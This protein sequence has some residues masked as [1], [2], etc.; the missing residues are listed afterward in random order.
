MVVLALSIYQSSF[1]ITPH[2]NCTI[3][4]IDPLTVFT[5]RPWIPSLSWFIAIASLFTRISLYGALMVRK[6]TDIIS[7]AAIT[8]QMAIWAK[9]CS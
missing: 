8:A 7:G 4:A 6:S 2:V 3:A 1:P 5:R 9:L